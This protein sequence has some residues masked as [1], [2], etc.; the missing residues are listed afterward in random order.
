MIKKIKI[1]FVLNDLRAANG[2]ASFAMAYFR[3]LN[4]NNY[5]IDFALLHDY[6]SPYYDEI[7]STGSSIFILP[8]IKNIFKHVNECKRILYKNDYQIIHD[9]LLTTSIPLMITSLICRVPIRILESHNT[10]LSSTKWKQVCNSILLPILMLVIN[11][12]FACGKEAGEA[13]FFNKNFKIIPNII[14]ASEFEFNS[15]KRDSLRMKYNCRNKIIVGTVAR[16]DKQKNPF[17]ALDVLARAHQKNPNIEYWWIGDGDLGTSVKEY[18]NQ[19]HM[20]SF[21]RFFGSRNDVNDLYQAMDV[22]FLPSIFEGLPISVLEAQAAGLVSVVSDSITKEVKFTDLVRFKSLN[23]S[24]DDWARSIIEQSNKKLLRDKY[25]NIL[26]NSQYYAPNA[27]RKLMKE[28]NRLIK[29]HD[30]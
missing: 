12:Q 1:L 23:A 4:K 14:S 24:F 20:T 10:R 8:P 25:K 7:K 21:V 16:I 5:Q 27:G 30:A 17:F 6:E 13:L 11:E 9:N 26:M 18:A 29:L 22:F 3:L 2:V 28:Y 15:K 19:K